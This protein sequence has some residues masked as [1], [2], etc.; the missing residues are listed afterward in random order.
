MNQVKRAFLHILQGK[1][2]Y[3]DRIVPVI[4]KD[5]RHDTTPSI[6]IHGLSKDK[7]YCVRQEVVVKRPLKEDHPLFDKDHPERKYPHVA[8][9]TKHAYEITINVWCNDERQRHHIVKQVKDCL[10]L[11]R[12]NHYSYCSKYDPETHVCKTIGEECKS[13]TTKGHAHMTGI[14]PSPEKYHCCS[15]LNAYGIIK[16]S[17]SI[18]GD[19]EEDELEHKPPLKRSIIKINLEYN[20]THVFPSNP[21]LC[22]TPPRVEAK[23]MDERIN[24]LTEKFIN[25]G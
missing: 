17:I 9:K 1:I 12:N 14:C 11:A 8:E 3:N 19:Y 5:H 16:P 21:V 7:D 25:H 24:E 18:G 22:F 13:R 4:I 23:S 10:F 6:T 15:L 2:V 20:E